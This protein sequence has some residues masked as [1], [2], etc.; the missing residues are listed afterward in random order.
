MLA[1][2]LLRFP[3]VNLRGVVSLSSRFDFTSES[4][5]FTRFTKEQLASPMFLW[6]P[7]NLKASRGVGIEITREE[8][9][10]RKLVDVAAAMNALAGEVPFLFVHGDADTVVPFSDLDLHAAAASKT[11]K[12][13]FRIRFV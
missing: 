3:W 7:K 12:Y 1:A 10:E 2:P 6:E 4:G 13:L 5:I 11:H 9:N 8:I